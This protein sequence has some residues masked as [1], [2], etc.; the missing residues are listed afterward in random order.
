MQIEVLTGEN[1]QLS[2]KLE[3]ALGKLEAVRLNDPLNII[4]IVS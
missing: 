2:M 1:K 4:F 3:T